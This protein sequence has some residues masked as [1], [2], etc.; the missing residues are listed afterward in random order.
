MAVVIAMKAQSSWQR[1]I[2]FFTVFITGT[3]VDRITSNKFAARWA[4]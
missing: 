3:E 1:D 4:S 2:R